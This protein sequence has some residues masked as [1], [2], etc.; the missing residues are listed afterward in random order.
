MGL[1]ATQES[2]MGVCY[3]QSTGVGEGGPGGLSQ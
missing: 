1:N 3:L 2:S